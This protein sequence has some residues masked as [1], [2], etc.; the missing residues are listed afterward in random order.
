[1]ITQKVKD[2]EIL[3]KACL[4]VRG[5]EEENLKDIRKDSPSCCKDNFRLVASII[6]SI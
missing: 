4:V 2:S 1:M 3:Y 5:F 6:A